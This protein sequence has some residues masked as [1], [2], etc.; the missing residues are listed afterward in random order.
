VNKNEKCEE[1]G[2]EALLTTNTMTVKTRQNE[3]PMAMKRRIKKAT[4]SNK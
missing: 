3:Q 1:A 4:D 2:E